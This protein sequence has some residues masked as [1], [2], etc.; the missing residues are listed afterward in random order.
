MCSHREELKGVLAAWFENTTKDDNLLQDD[1]EVELVPPL[2][3]SA[4][5]DEP[6]RP[7]WLELLPVGPESDAPVSKRSARS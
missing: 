7:L 6:K 1:V 4:D 2:A 3:D 5:E